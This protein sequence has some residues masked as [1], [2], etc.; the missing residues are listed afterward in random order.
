M[1]QETV[2][3]MAEKFAL[4]VFKNLEAGASHASWL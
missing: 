3:A 2:Q 1:I 4:C